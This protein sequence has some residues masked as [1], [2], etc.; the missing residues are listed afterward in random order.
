MPKYY[1]FKVACILL[2]FVL[3]SA[4]MSMRVTAN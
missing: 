2:L 1:D 4:C 3:W